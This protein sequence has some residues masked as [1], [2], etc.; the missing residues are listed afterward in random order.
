MLFVAVNCLL[1]LSFRKW[2]QAATFGLICGIF[3]IAA[4]P[5]ATLQSKTQLA[6]LMADRSMMSDIAVLVTIEVSLCLSYCFLASKKIFGGELSRWGKVLQWYPSLLI[7]PALFYLL[8][9]TMYAMPGQSFGSIAWTLAAITAVGMPLLSYALRKLLPEDDFRLEVHFLVSLFV[10]VL[11]LI[12]T[13]NGQVAYA[14][15]DTST[16]WKMLSAATLL[17][18]CAFGGGFIWNR[19][20][21][22]RQTDKTIK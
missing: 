8:T 6:D 1:K 17:F 5:T 15:V 14:A 12:S 11:G 10:C 18:A 19:M 22:R 2:W 3:V 13:V 20:K 7:F 21:W 9:Q 4:Y 16:D